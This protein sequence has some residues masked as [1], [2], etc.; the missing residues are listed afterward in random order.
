METVARRLES[1]H[2]SKYERVVKLY[3]ESL[4]E[5]AKE[6]QHLYHPAPAEFHTDIIEK[7][8]Y[9]MVLEDVTWR[10]IIIHQQTFFNINIGRSYMNCKILFNSP[11]FTTATRKKLMKDNLIA[12]MKFRRPTSSGKECVP[13]VSIII[14]EIISILR[15]VSIFYTISLNHTVQWTNYRIRRTPKKHMLFRG[16]SDTGNSSNIWT[17]LSNFSKKGGLD[18]STSETLFEFCDDCFEED[19]TSS[20]DI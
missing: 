5:M 19:G 2:I 20:S 4:N 1:I 15:P 7:L 16:S 12:W 11:S 6:I 9:T 8:S 3:E 14:S 18:P 17:A 13:T 10:Y